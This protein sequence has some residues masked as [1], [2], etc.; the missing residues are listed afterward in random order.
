MYS[1]P[2]AVKNQ[3]NNGGVEIREKHRLAGLCFLTAEGVLVDKAGTGLQR[4]KVRP[5][6]QGWV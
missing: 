4:G 6:Q 2:L 5:Q 1:W 3:D